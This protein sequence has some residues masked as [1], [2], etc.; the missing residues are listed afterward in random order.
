[1][2]FMIRL[3]LWEFYLFVSAIDTDIQ[4]ANLFIHAIVVA[5]AKDTDGLGEHS[6]VDVEHPVGL[7]PRLRQ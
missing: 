3:I 2:R 7:V 6:M 5:F 4:S 1:M